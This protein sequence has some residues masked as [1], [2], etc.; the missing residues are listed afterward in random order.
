[1]KGCYVYCTDKELADHIRER[2]KAYA[3]G[4]TGVN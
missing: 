2:M 3:S 4:L 1:M